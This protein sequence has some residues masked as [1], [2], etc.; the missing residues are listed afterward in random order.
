METPICFGFELHIKASHW[1]L[2]GRPSGPMAE[3]GPQIQGHNG[4]DDYKGYEVMIV[5]GIN[6]D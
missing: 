3:V 1:L 4:W 5:R 2:V 6:I